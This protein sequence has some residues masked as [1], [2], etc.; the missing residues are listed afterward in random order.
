MAEP[1]PQLSCPLTQGAQA[2]DT[3]KASRGYLFISTAGSGS[4]SSLGTQLIKG[5]CTDAGF[6]NWINVLDWSFN[7]EQGPSAGSGSSGS[8][9]GKVAFSPFNFTKYVDSSTPAIFNQLA[10]G[11]KVDMTFVFVDGAKAEF[12]KFFVRGAGFLSQ[13]LS[14]TPGMLKE[15]IAFEYGCI[16]IWI[17]PRASAGYGAY[18]SKGWSILTNIGGAC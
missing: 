14:K 18:V 11:Y 17:K 9:A 3:Y 6:T 8:G 16:E 15:D 7:F 4:S 2:T 5:T 1:H 12:L 13:A 10:T